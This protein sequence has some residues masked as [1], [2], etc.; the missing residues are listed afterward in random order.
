MSKHR[1][2][3]PWTIEE[4]S[5]ARRAAANL[6]TKDEARHMAVNFAKLPELLGAA[7]P[8]PRLNLKVASHRSPPLPTVVRQ[9]AAAPAKGLA[10]APKSCSACLAA[11]G[12]AS[13]GYFGLTSCLIAVCA[14]G[15]TLAGCA[16]SMPFQARDK[17]IVRVGDD[18]KPVTYPV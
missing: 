2:P 10:S 11:C 5:D 18:D 15:I 17:V 1:F 4:L 8:L 16:T 12:G 3:P 13:R 9:Q 7:K 14:A 6:L